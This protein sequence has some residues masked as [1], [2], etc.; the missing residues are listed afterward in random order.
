MNIKNIIF[1]IGGV[2]I[3][4]NPIYLY[5]NLFTDKSE[6]EFF[7]KNICSPEW[8]LHQ[9]AGYSLSEATKELQIQHPRYKNEIAAFYKD[10]DSMLGG[11]IFE[12]S[13]LI[14]A[15]KIKYRLF[16]LTNWSAETF[17]FA[18]N[19]FTFLKD[20]EGI[21]VSGQEKMVKPDRTIYELLLNRYGIRA[22][23]SLFIDDNLNNI[24]TAKEMEFL[25]IHIKDS[26]PLSEQL[27]KLGLL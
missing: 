24:H 27:M 17:P 3:D 9:D 14:K 13:R 10:W 26:I 8:N 22:N 15:L 7:L 18:I 12:N 4:W 5:D 21:V 19:R 2:L 6:M 16:A 25:T 1:D 11:E 23:E 20:F